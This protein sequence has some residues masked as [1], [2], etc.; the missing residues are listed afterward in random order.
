MPNVRLT[1]KKNKPG[2]VAH[3]F[4]V[5]WSSL[6]VFQLYFLKVLFFFSCS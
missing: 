6:A 1:G 2:H 5:P 3:H 4:D